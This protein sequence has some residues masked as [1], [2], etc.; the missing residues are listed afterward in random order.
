MNGR[1]ISPG[2]FGKGKK[3]IDLETVVRK[4]LNFYSRERDKVPALSKKIL[5]TSFPG[6]HWIGE[7]KGGK[8]YWYSEMYF[9]WREDIGND[10]THVSVVCSIL[11]CT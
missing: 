2:I 3:S 9:F 7:K 5:A 1:E 4:F 6:R 8:V 11:L 10:Q